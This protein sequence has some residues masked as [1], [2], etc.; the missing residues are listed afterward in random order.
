MSCWRQYQCRPIQI[1]FICSISR[2]LSLLSSLLTCLSESSFIWY[3]HYYS[4]FAVCTMPC[5]LL[6]TFMYGI[7]VFSILILIYTI[8]SAY[9]YQRYLSG[10]LALQESPRRK[11]AY[12]EKNIDWKHIV[13]LLKIKAGN[14]KS[15]APPALLCWFSWASIPS[16]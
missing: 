16:Q 8:Q 15:I 9:S 4:S 14:N 6:C 3:W 12:L 13:E 11:L 7:D 5:V 10:I 1:V 2:V